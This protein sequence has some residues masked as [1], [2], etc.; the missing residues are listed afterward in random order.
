MSGEIWVGVAVQTRICVPMCKP[1]AKTPKH[2]HY[3]TAAPQMRPRAYR[4]L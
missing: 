3:R 1:R 2:K 4:I